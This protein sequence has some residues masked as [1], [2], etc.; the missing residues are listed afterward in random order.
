NE[1][2]GHFRIPALAEREALPGHAAR[3]RELFEARER[4]LRAE[5]DRMQAELRRLRDELEHRLARLEGERDS[6]LAEVDSYRGKYAALEAATTAL[7][8]EIASE[9]E[10]LE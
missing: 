9:R 3:T 10:N 7:R 6:A 2:S 4:E 8:S 1:T 5:R